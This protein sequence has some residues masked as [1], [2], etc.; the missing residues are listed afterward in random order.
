[1]EEQ[2]QQYTDATGWNE[3]GREDVS[4]ERYEVSLYLYGISSGEREIR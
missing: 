1:M 4:G 3:C 2:V